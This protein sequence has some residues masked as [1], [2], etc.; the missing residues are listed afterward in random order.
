MAK[1]GRFEGQGTPSDQGRAGL[2]VPFDPEADEVRGFS[3]SVAELEW[4]LLI[5]SMLYLLV[6]GSLVLERGIMIGSM[7]GFAGFVL[8]FRYANFYRAE[9]RWK[10]AIETWVMIAFITL[11]LTQTG[12]LES[13]LLNLYLLVIIVAALTLG[14]LMTLLEVGLIVA[15]YVWLGYRGMGPEIFSL[16]YMGR[17]FAENAPLLLVAYLTT[18]LSADMLKARERIKLLSVTDELTGLANMREFQQVM[19]REH[20]KAVRYARNYAVAMIDVDNLKQINDRYGHEVGNRVIKRV[21]RALSELV[22][23]SDAVARYGGDEFIML[24]TEANRVETGEAV[25]RIMDHLERIS[26]NVPGTRLVPKV[27]VG[28]AAYPMD[29]TEPRE[30]MERADESM[31][32]AKKERRAPE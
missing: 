6:P 32:E 28:F 10:L 15:C 8:A 18:M 27:S 4:L 1:Q 31:Y 19:Q 24:F 21:G 25:K 14:K 17:L 22:R 26:V 7:V 23:D 20:A 3:R 12:N 9:S 16:S 30:L 2:L 5:L 13:P 29:G 11:V